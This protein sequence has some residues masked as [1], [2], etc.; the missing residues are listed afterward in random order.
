M[1]DIKIISLLLVAI[2][3]TGLFLTGGGILFSQVPGSTEEALIEQPQVIKTLS[4]TNAD[5]RSVMMY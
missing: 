3:G 2:I 4:F 5:I 1:K